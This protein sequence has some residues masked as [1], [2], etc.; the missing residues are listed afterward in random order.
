M[1]LRHVFWRAESMP[2][3]DR[4]QETMERKWL[5]FGIQNGIVNACAQIML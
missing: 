1:A 3:V 5:Q 2:R 4:A